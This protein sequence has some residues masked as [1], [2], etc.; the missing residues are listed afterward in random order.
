MG[1]A[2]RTRSLGNGPDLPVQQG[3]HG[4]LVIVDTFLAEDL[5]DY[6]RFSIGN[7]Q[8]SDRS[9]FIVQDDRP[10]ETV[11]FAGNIEPL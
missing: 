9:R 8:E 7:G 2:D 10:C 1:D 6:G 5:P 4:L 11:Q 3:F